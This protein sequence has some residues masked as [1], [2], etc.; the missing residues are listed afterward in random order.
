MQQAIIWDPEARNAEK[1]GCSTN[2]IPSEAAVPIG[3]L[4]G[5][6]VLAD[7]KIGLDLGRPLRKGRSGGVAGGKAGVGLGT[8]TSPQRRP[9]GMTMSVIKCR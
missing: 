3:E 5:V 6:Y 4:G 7:R 1:R 8:P 9:A 2:E